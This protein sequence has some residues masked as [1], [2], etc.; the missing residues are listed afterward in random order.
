M[1]IGLGSSLGI[2]PAL[3]SMLRATPGSHVGVAS[4]LFNTS[5][6]VG[7]LMGV[8][9]LGAFLGSEAHFLRGFHAA[10]LLSGAL[11]LLCILG[12]L[13]WTQSGS[14]ADRAPARELELEAE[15]AAEA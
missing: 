7:S 4:G 1:P 14:G 8:A 11:M 13:A 15:L 2:S 10:V 5:R 12:T 3:V 9:V 6:Q